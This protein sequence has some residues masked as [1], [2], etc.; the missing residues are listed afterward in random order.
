M[1]NAVS[2]EARAT[3]ILVPRA[4]AGAAAALDAFAKK[5]APDM[6][7]GLMDAQGTLF[8]EFPFWGLS[9]K[10][11]E[12]ARGAPSAPSVKPA[13]FSDLHAWILKVLLLADVGPPLWSGPDARVTTVEELQR[14]CNVSRMTA[15]RFLQTL[16]SQDFVQRSGGTSSLVR[17]AD[18]VRRW[19]DYTQH[20]RFRGS[21]RARKLRA[22]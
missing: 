3:V 15:Y 2:H 20:A 7:W 4:T 17:R 9:L 21:T 19:F 22:V 12:H 16:E 1:R 8:L 14:H 11:R 5:Y 6:G 18:L 13:L 10:E